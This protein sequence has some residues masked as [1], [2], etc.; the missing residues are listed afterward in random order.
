MSENSK[1]YTSSSIEVLEGLEAVRKRPEMYIGYTDQTGLH[2][3]I[4][5]VVDNSVDEAVA[6][7][8]DTI[9]VYL[10]KGKNNDLVEI[11]D[12]GRGMPVDIHKDKQVSALELIMTVLHAG[13]KFGNSA[14]KVSGGLHGV[15]VS[16]VN[17]L[18]EYCEV[19]SFRDGKKYVQR[20]SKGEP[21][22]PVKPEGDAEG[23]VGTRVIFEA[24]S[25]IFKDSV[26]SYDG[27]A[28]RLR[29]LAFLNRGLTVIFQDERQKNVK[30][31]EF[32]FP[33]GVLSFLQELNSKKSK[34][35]KEPIIMSAQEDK[36]EAEVVLQYTDGTREFFLAYANNIR[37]DEGGLHVTGFRKALTKVM[38]DMLKTYK[39]EKEAKSGFTGEDV[40]E[41]ITGVINLKVVNPKFKNQTKDQLTGTEEADVNIEQFLRNMVYEQLQKY[42]ERN[43]DE[44]KTMLNRCILSYK[45]RDAAR[46][47]REAIKRKSA[48]DFG[49]GLPGKLADASEKD[50]SKCE[51][52]VVEGDSAGGSAKQG[53]NRDY[54]A[55]LPLRGKMTNVEKFIA[56]KSNGKGL[57]EE[58]ILGS[59]T[60]LPLIQAIGTGV[61]KFF[62]IS[63]LRYHKIVIMADADVDGSH[64]IALLLT[65][66]YRYM[67]DLIVKNH[68]YIAMPP[69]YKLQYKKKEHYV[70]SD[71]ERDKIIQKIGVDKNIDIQRYKG[72]GEMNPTQLW[73][74]TMNPEDRRI[75]RVRL[76][77][78]V[79]ADEMFSILMGKSAESRRQF[80]Q[81]N[82]HMV[83]LEDLSL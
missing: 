49:L 24:D 40:R 25:G 18:S 38:N 59:D 60:L 17:A 65:F 55:I 67:P 31:R 2:K 71:E 83:E 61:G 41:G 34:I 44:A 70:F 28:Q 52:F 9:E 51:L 16:V 23:N 81:E 74:T 72:L 33:G 82:A 69:L 11:R 54:Q 13:G 35:P 10:R 1:E 32:N 7:F 19:Q 29:E 76:E 4:F 66:F 73:E 3:L 6:G 75:I 68:L 15:G 77:D 20:Y 78:V 62:D 46:R 48:L 57:R 5:E 53:R 27:I 22:G 37:N 64:I 63:K 36:I 42:M 50:P 80:I 26:I 58:K 47:A 14:Y 39:M 8:C 12:N 45:E 21:L 79:A 56:D 30:R 43:P